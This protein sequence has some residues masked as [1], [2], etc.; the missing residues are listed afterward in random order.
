MALRDCIQR[1]LR[2]GV[3]TPTQAAKIAKFDDNGDEATLKL[4]ESFI[5][6]TQERGRRV[7]LHH[8]H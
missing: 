5:Q 8:C 4:L 1:A 7:N 2:A 3:I 6:E